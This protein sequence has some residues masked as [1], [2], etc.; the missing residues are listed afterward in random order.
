[1]G[2]QPAD[3]ESGERRGD[4]AEVEDGEVAGAILVA[5]EVEEVV[6]RAHPHG[7]YG[8]TAGKEDEAEEVGEGAG[9]GGQVLC[10]GEHDCGKEEGEEGGAGGEDG[11]AAHDGAGPAAVVEIASEDAGDGAADGHRPDVD[12]GDVLL[13]AEMLLGEDNVERQ[14]VGDGEA[15]EG[16]CDEGVEGG[17]AEHGDGAEE[18]LADGLRL[19]EHGADGLSHEPTADHGDQEEDGHGGEEKGEIEGKARPRMP[20][21]SPHG[22]ADGKGGDGGGELH[23]PEETAAQAGWDGFGDDVVPGDAEDAVSEGD[24]GEGDGEEPDNEA[25]VLDASEPEVADEDEEGEPPDQ[26]RPSE[27][28]ELVGAVAEG[29]GHE[30][31]GRLPAELLDNGDEADNQGGWG[32]PGNEEREHGGGIDP[33]EP[34]HEEGGLGDDDAEVPARVLGALVL[35][36]GKGGRHLSPGVPR[37]RGRSGNA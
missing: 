30:Y 3:D 6:G 4:G 23:G 10:E 14:G 34:A 37:V 1:M 18:E 36:R 13:D 31:L 21:R 29:G 27:E 25:A 5:A 19:I 28:G 22:K 33:G 26:D 16:G 9:S 7:A 32:Q 8:G 24:A 35:A 15:E 20:E 11:A 17:I 2:E 12:A